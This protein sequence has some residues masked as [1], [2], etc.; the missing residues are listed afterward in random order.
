MKIFRF[1]FKILL[2]LLIISL[3]ISG[4]LI[5]Y[6]SLTEYKPSPVE[7]LEIHGLNKQQPGAHRS[8]SLLTWNIGYCGL[9]KGE[10]F[11]YDGGKSTRPEFGNY[12]NY[13]NGVYNLLSKQDSIDF[14]L[15]QEVDK[16]AKRSYFINQIEL[17][18]NNFKD[19]NYQFARNYF[20]KFIPFPIFSPM[21]KVEA[22]LLQLQRYKP[23]EAQRF[24]APVNF[25]WPKR[26]FF[27]D[28]CFMVTKYILDNNKQ[29]VVINLHNSAFDEGS[30]LR[31]GEM[32]LL[33][34]LMTLEYTIGN[35]VIA[36]GDWNQNPPGFDTKMFITGESKITRHIEP[37]NSIF[38]KG[39][40]WAFD[41]SRP[42]NR[43]VDKAYSKGYTPVSIIDYFLLSPNIS[44]EEVRT[45]TNGFGYS[46]HHPVYLRV[47]L[48]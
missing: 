19:F 22:G 47:H 14:I 17:M 33:K 32:K 5:A 21:A 12:Q 9:G 20:V 28:R 3:V 40:T 25:S 16:D 44:I 31:S 36:G 42:T 23:V 38:P 11:F 15:L 13:L 35:Y 27:L 10:D 18:A 4:T 24:S 39:W 37:G 45:I 1:I 43:D 46:D 6:L 2:L 26:I 8:F 48:N 34:D 30:V 29:L 41:S 7:K